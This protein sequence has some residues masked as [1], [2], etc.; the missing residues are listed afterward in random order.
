MR[1]RPGGSH[2]LRGCHGELEE[3]SWWEVVM[4]VVGQGPGSPACRNGVRAACMLLPL[5]CIVGN[6][7]YRLR[8]YLPR[9]GR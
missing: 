7:N 6:V 8:S 9:P 1:V 4:G 2:P 3:S 5:K